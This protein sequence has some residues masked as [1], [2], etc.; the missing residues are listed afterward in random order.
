MGNNMEDIHLNN[1]IRVIGWVEV[2]DSDRAVY[3]WAEPV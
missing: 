1:R 2:T 3:H